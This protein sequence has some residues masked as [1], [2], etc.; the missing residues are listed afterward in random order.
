MPKT[1]ISFY[2]GKL[3][4]L[5][6]IL[7]RIPDHRIY[8]EAF[9]GGGAVFFAKPPSESEVVNDSDGMAVNF[10][11]V[12]REDF[13]SLREKV[14]GTL[15][16]RAT[17][18]VAWAI[19]RMPHLF[20]PLQRAWAFHVAT[21]MGFASHIGSWGH[22]RYGKRAKSFLNR[23]LAFDPHLGERLLPV[24]I[25]CRDG[26]E[27]I[28]M[29]DAPDAFHYADPPYIGTDMGHYGGYTEADYRRLLDTLSGITG[30]FLLSG[31]PTDVLLEHARKNGWHV[32]SFDKQKTAVKHRD[33]KRRPRKT[34][35]LVANYPIGDGNI[36]KPNINL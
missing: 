17:Y 15:F 3:N 23:K 21:N 31:F 24:T 6:H 14:E 33:G 34:E 28:R 9:F 29:Y 30:K 2:G 8:T 12:L 27:V 10:Y 4:M 7:P 1:P 11:R 26:A 19:Y 36:A 20:S 22:D 13:N 5:G 16:S 35:L 18:S 32:Q 25:E